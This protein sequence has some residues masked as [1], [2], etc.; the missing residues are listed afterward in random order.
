MKVSCQAISLP[1]GQIAAQA[2]VTGDSVHSIHITECNLKPQFGMTIAYPFGNECNPFPMVLK[3]NGCV[4]ITFILQFE[5]LKSGLEPLE[6]ENESI[7]ELHYEIMPGAGNMLDRLDKLTLRSSIEGISERRLPV[8]PQLFPDVS[9]GTRAAVS[10]HV[11]FSLL[12]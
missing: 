5:A 4:S 9:S 10:N 1:T 3:P 12:I 11:I 8:P 2:C 6:E 7:L